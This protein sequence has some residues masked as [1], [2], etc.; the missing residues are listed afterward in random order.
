MRAG[1]VLC[2]PPEGNCQAGSRFVPGQRR[3][4]QQ[5][6]QRMLAVVDWR[7][8]S[9][10]K[11]CHYRKCWPEVAAPIR[12]YA[13]ALVAAAGHAASAC[14]RPLRC[15]LLGIT[16][17]RRLMACTHNSRCLGERSPDGLR[18]GTILRELRERGPSLRSCGRLRQ[19]AA[20]AVP[21]ADLPRR[22]CYK[23]YMPCVLVATAEAGKRAV[24]RHRRRSRTLVE[25]C[26][27]GALPA[28]VQRRDVFFMAF[29]TTE[30]PRCHD[31]GWVE[32]RG[33]PAAQ[34]EADRPHTRHRSARTASRVTTDAKDVLNEPPS[35]TSAI[36]ARA[37]H[38]P[39]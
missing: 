24:R 35:P 31:E 13:M 28:R 29:T 25:C 12:R 9:A 15:F 16:P 6:H 19:R 23:A 1:G 3:G 17:A 37:Q 20:A 8:P 11:G 33:R 22:H 21:P 4:D 18:P 30:P 5:R 38:V 27:R 32:R 34:T 36:A 14:L 10:T 39:F 7:V 26:G 2:R